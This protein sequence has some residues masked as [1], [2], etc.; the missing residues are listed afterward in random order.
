MSAKKKAKQKA[1]VTR[2]T[3]TVLIV[4]GGALLL[5]LVYLLV[6]NY[7]QQQKDQQLLREQKVRL[8]GAEKDIRE[9]ADSFLAQFSAEEI[10]EKDFSKKCGESSA[11]FGRGAITCKTSFS[12]QIIASQSLEQIGK[13]E[14]ALFNAVNKKPAF[15]N[16]K[17]SYSGDSYT[18]GNRAYEVKSNYSSNESTQCL[19]VLDTYTREQYARVSSRLDSVGNGAYVVLASFAC[20]EGTKEPI[21]PLRD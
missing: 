16:V 21:Y 9:V 18:N 5:S 10:S 7:I 13:T 19:F 6:G 2:I 1:S 20:R 14:D 12:A 15:S 4:I 8:D 3:K 17:L 11:K